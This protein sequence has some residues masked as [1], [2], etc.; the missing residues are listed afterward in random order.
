MS[1]DK[2]PQPYVPTI[3]RRAALAWVGVVGAAM[4]AGS[5]VVACAPKAGGASARGYGTDPN[6]VKPAPAPWPRIMTAVQLQTAAVLADHILPASGGAPS[7]SALGVPDF[8]NEWVSAPYPDQAKD[9]PTLLGGLDR[10]RSK[11][12]W[13]YKKEAWLLDA[14]TRDSMLGAL[15]KSKEEDLAFFKRFRR[16]TIGAYYTTPQ[17][18]KDLGYVG[19]VARTKDPGPSPEVMAQIEAELT[20]LKL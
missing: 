14:G 1:D 19:N 9:R 10:L 4:A 3:D 17:G 16:L 15:A 7:A 20:R 11:A 18:F 6:L 2:L 8:L 5:T 13:K 12:L